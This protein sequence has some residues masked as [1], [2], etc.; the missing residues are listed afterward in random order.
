MANE[1]V[2]TFTIEA[3]Q[4]E[5]TADR[6]RNDLKTLNQDLNN[7][8]T[9]PFANK[10]K[11]AFDDL[12]KRTDN[13]K[14][15]FQKLS[16]TKLEKGQFD[17]I[18]QG[19]FVAEKKINDLSNRIRSLQKEAANP[20]NSKYFKY[21]VD[22]IREAES[23]LSRFESKIKTLNA[24]Q[25]GLSSGRKSGGRRR[26]GETGRALL[27]VADDFVPAGFNKPFNAVAK[28]LLAIKGLSFATLAPLGA[29]VAI[30]YGI[31]KWSEKVKE[32]AARRLKYEEEIAIAINKQRI[33]GIEAVA[34]LDQSRLDS[35][36][37]KY[38]ASRT[39]SDIDN[40]K[41]LRD[42]REKLFRGG[43][44]TGDTGA[45]LLGEIQQY[46][47]KITELSTKLTDDRNKAFDLRFE[48]FKKAQESELDVQKRAAEL[49]AKSVD[50]GKTKVK[51]LGKTFNELFDG[52]FLRSNQ[53]NPFVALYSE[54]DKSLKTLR[55]N[56]KGLSKD[57]IA[58]FE[59]IETRT[60]NL[61]LFEARLNNNLSAFDL[62]DAAN[63]FRNPLQT[64]S[65][66]ETKR[67]QDT[68]IERFL[69]DNPNFL[70]LE[71]KTEVDNDTRLKILNKSILGQETLKQVNPFQPLQERLDKQLSIIYSGRLSS[72]ELGIADRKLI[73]ITNGLNP[74]ELSSRIRE[75]AALARER[76]ADRLENAEKEAKIMR[77]N[78]FKVQEQIR[79]E[80]KKLT[81]IAEKEG[82]A[83]IKS[84]IEIVDKT[85]GGARVLG[86]SPKPEDTLAQFGANLFN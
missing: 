49:F 58:Q 59:A 72:G 70:F 76:E 38:L 25:S 48:N 10:Y 31:V 84:L 33:A 43:A 32:D 37:G 63:N 62:R 69:R 77:E 26:L 9:K 6:F 53:N 80:L 46:D 50:E 61:R 39:T 17:T 85:D 82:I 71:G 1:L 21:Y 57:L 12:T 68:I 83:G 29:M 51:E 34:S 78:S 55:E 24:E 2:T 23:E 67:E 42:E 81:A 74:N 47:T 27:E 86:A 18:S 28:E 41:K 79:D 22:G 35:Q 60:N 30:G 8:D 64:K 45:R 13:L 66:D 4:A 16:Q 75:A 7:L 19:V 40:L 15:G 73:S 14:T 5:R 65:A 20:S 52:L 54:A 11:S 44:N 56:T 36:F 3:K